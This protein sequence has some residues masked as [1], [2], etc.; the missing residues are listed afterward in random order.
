MD[1]TKLNPGAPNR[2]IAEQPPAASDAKVSIAVLSFSR[3]SRDR[4]VLRQC[5][6]LKEL[7]YSPV[8]IGYGDQGE[9][10]GHDFE[11]WPVP[12]PTTWHRIRTVARQLPAHLGGGAAKLG[13]W[14][15]PRHRWALDRLRRHRCS[16]VL[17]NDWPALV[18]AAAW[19]IESG[20]KLI[21]DTHEFATLEFDER[22]WWRVVYKPFVT[23]LE[24]AYIREADDVITV[25]PSLA[26]ALEA[27]YGLLK[28]VLV[29]RNTPNRI[30][31]SE[32][33]NTRWPLRVLYH[34]AVLPDRGLEALIDSLPMWH[35]A[36][37]VTIRGD[38]SQGYIR[39]LQ[40]QVAAVGCERQ[41][42]FESAVRPEEVM[43]LAAR[44]ADLG[45]H[46]T[47]LDT[48]QR[49]FS[50]PNKLFE[51]VGAGLAVAVSPG[52]DLKRV[53]ERHGFGV[54]SSG[55]KPQAIAAT[56]NALSQA[57]VVELR[58]NARA[59]AADLCWEQERV[60]LRDLLGVYLGQ[61]H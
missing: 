49:H 61:S 31:L 36:H 54:V 12:Q 33:S 53:V 58:A 55:A 26:R 20:A 21:Y 8:V 41:V 22:A 51:Y 60:A 17:A 13:F 40:Q 37:Q 25:G 2:A 3:I 27:Q 29:I 45:V 38:G 52:A 35:E 59:A 10:I 6:L 23:Q 42:T 56:I 43:P 7:G 57:R 28:R 18:V 15:E 44:T 11:S 19:K 39:K 9:A 48:E 47:P 14:M 30:E 24:R 34:G 50:L 32:T 46:F 4:R 5:A 16:L 1:Q